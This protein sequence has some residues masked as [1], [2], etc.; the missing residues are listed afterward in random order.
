MLTPDTNVE[1]RVFDLAYNNP[2]AT[3]PRIGGEPFGTR[4]GLSRECGGV[5]GAE[6]QFCSWWFL[7]TWQAGALHSATL[8]CER[9]GSGR[10]FQRR[11]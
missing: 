11:R 8:T 10:G 5:R 7:G 6:W 1:E 2:L 9:G 3:G 4:V